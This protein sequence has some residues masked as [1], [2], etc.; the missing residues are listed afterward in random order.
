[1]QSHSIDLP[2]ATD[3]TLFVISQAWLDPSRLRM[4]QETL[5]SSSCTLCLKRGKPIRLQ[6]RSRHVRVGGNLTNMWR[7]CAI[8]RDAATE[9]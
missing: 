4:G 5:V 3:T 8:T 2:I 1:M 9:R 7:D 6:Q